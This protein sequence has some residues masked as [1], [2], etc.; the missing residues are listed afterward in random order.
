[1]ALEGQ[2]GVG[3]AHPL[4]VIDDLQA[5]AS[6]IDSNDINAMSIGIDSI[7]YQLLNDG[8]WSLNDLA[9]CYLV[10]HGIGKKLNDVQGQG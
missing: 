5:G 3:L 10:G 6:S 2:S 4:A 8:G 9:S 7:F 1:M